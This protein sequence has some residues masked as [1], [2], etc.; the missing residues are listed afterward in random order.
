MKEY[1]PIYFDWLDVTQDL[2]PEEK[3]N[4]IDAVVSYAC[5]LEYEQYLT[6]CA[7]IAFRFFK[8]QVDRNAAI[9]EVR[10]KAGSN[11]AN[12]NK[13][14]Q[15]PT[16]ANKP[17]QT[18]TNAPKEKDKEKDKD[19]NKE[20]ELLFERFWKAYPRKV[21]KPGAKRAFDKL[22]V[23]EALLQ[24]MLTAI[25]KQKR[26]AQWQE[27]G[28][29]YIPHPATWLNGHRWE[30]EV[31]TGKKQNPAANFTERD[32]DGVDAEMQASLARELEEFK[33]GAC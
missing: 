16:N 7:R 17:E 8:G 22:G 20:K 18:A 28:G 30:D 25:D 4:L 31:C 33:R 11:K 1:V 27:N 32:Y 14:E 23:D 3:G 21:N 19:T 29:Q 2:T 26:T 5:G 9:S 10:S 13:P 6:G 24:T 12:T 15:T